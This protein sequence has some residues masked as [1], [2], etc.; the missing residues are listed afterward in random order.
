ME[1]LKVEVYATNATN[2]AEEAFTEFYFSEF[3]DKV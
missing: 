1:G 2:C 3:N